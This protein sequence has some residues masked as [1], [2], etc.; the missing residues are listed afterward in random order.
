MTMSHQVKLS[1]EEKRDWFFDQV[2]AR[3]KVRRFESDEELIEFMQFARRTFKETFGRDVSGTFFRQTLDEL[4]VVRDHS[5]AY[6]KKSRWLFAQLDKNQA[7]RDSKLQA[8]KAVDDHFGGKM[9][10]DV[11]NEMWDE[12][13]DLAE[14][15]EPSVN[16]D[17]YGQGSLFD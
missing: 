1:A 5:E 9:H 17:V 11:F 8:K 12:W 2:A 3:A 13:H 15:P 6:E 16:I 10:S 14:H 7:L 4:G